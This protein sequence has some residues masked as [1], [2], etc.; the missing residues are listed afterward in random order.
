MKICRRCR[1]YCP[2]SIYITVLVLCAVISTIG[3]ISISSHISIEQY[4]E[5]TEVFV[6]DENDLNDANIKL[7]SNVHL[8]HEEYFNTT[9]LVCHYPTLTIDNPE[10][11]KHLHPV[12]ESRP[13]CEKIDNWVYVDNG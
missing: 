1:C 6:V 2:R 5:S 3:Y 8:L 11:W 4:H 7:T 13:D 9:H 10:I 12:K